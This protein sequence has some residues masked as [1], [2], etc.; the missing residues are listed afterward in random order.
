MSESKLP[1]RLKVRK[2]DWRDVQRRR[3]FRDFY[4]ETG[5][6]VESAIEAG[7]SQQTA[8]THAWRMAAAAEE[9]LRDQCDHLGID[10]LGLVTTLLRNLQATEP[11]W[12]S[13]TEKWD[14]FQNPTAQLAAY[15]RLKAILE[16]TPPKPKFSNVK[17]GVAVSAKAATQEAFMER[18]KGKIKGEGVQLIQAAGAGVDV[19]VTVEHNNGHGNG[20]D[21]TGGDGGGGI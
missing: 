20:D 6:A 19:R 21:P 13:K 5:A 3:R 7:Y 10:K 4:L 17:V 14:H 12:N 16:P 1:K 9:T 8:R 11:K 18:N 2:R 15:D